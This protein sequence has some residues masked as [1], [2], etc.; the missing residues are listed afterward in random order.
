MKKI[1]STL[2]LTLLLGISVIPVHAFAPNEHQFEINGEIFSNHIR[3]SYFKQPDNKLDGTMFGLNASYLM[4]LGRNF[5]KANLRYAGSKMEHKWY[6]GVISD[7]GSAFL[8][9]G[10]GLIGRD[11]ELIECVSISPYTGLGYT[12]FNN[13]AGKDLLRNPA[14]WHF[15]TATQLYIP[16][17][18]D[19]KVPF[20]EQCF[21]L[22][23]NAE[24]DW[25]M[26][27]TIRTHLLTCKAENTNSDGYGARFAIGASMD[28]V[29]FSAEIK[30]FFHFWKVDGTDHRCMA[31][32]LSA[33]PKYTSRMIGV[34]FG[35][36][37]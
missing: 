12:Y 13:N 32:G 33:D 1:I 26:R 36:K 23:A 24:I 2:C 5:F 16:F 18:V 8:F 9:E 27:G 37:L 17:G 34:S 22:I 4:G 30:P 7:K 19:I 6:R 10:R 14:G 29:S 28:F 15:A 35:V 11:V 20:E 31:C 3:E 21:N 25:L